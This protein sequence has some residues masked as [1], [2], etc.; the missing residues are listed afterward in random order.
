MAYGRF[1]RTRKST[2]S[3]GRKRTTRIRRVGSGY[4]KVATRFATVG[5]ARNVEKKYWDKT[6]GSTGV[7]NTTG[8]DGYSVMNGIMFDAGDWFTYGFDETATPLPTSN[9]MLKGVPTGT[10]ARSRIG[11]KINVKYVKGAFTFNAGTVIVKSDVNPASDGNTWDQGG[12]A[13]AGASNNSKQQYLRTT[14]RFVIVKDLQ[15]NSTDTMV[16]WN[17]VFES[18]NKQHGVHSELNVD[19]MGRF[20]VIHDKTFTLDSDTPQRT[21]NWSVSG[22][23]VGSVR[24]NGPGTNA[25]TDRG[26]YVLWSAFVMGYDRSQS[27]NRHNLSLPA[28]VGH[29]RLCFTDD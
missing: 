2:R 27:G 5:F 23:K 16:A 13:F 14:Y 29:S 18:T 26:L 17:Q 4:R 12:E 19:N 6:Y 8:S 7:M 9:D 3:Y 10:T 28:P 22:S 20:M 11:N 25:L 15:V 1:R 21:V 24:Y